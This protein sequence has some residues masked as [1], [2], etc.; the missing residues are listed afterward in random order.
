LNNI[1]LKVE[2]RTT[3]GNSP[4]RALRRSGRIPAILYGAGTES[5]MLSV[6]TTAMEN[7]VKAGNVGRSIF[8][9]AV[10]GGN[11]ARAAMIKELQ[12]DP[13]SQDILHIDFYE[14]NM[15]R[16][17]KVMV[18]VV[19]TGKSVGVE[20]GGMLQIIRRD[21]EVLC[22]PNAIPQEITIDITDLDIGS[23]VHVEDIAL[24]GDVEIPHD[25]NFTVL[26]VLSPKKAE[27]EELEEEEALAEGEAA[28]A[29]EAEEEGTG[30]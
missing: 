1:E 23:S 27:G 10:D 11:E 28:E 5:V 12:T 22:L 13:V 7:I 15:D 19:A 25:V 14:V 3:T 30:E 4:A 16:K 9:L 20:L 24:G 2:T 26:T 18:P 21:L 17:V 6:D 29:A 8:D